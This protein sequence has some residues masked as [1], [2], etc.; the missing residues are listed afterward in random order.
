MIFTCVEQFTSSGGQAV[1]LTRLLLAS[2][3]EGNFTSLDLLKNKTL[4]E[5]AQTEGISLQI[6]TTN[7]H[8]II[9]AYG[10]GCVDITVLFNFFSKH[11]HLKEIS[12]SNYEAVLAKLGDTWVAKTGMSVPLLKE[13]RKA[14]NELISYH[15]AEVSFVIDYSKESLKNPVKDSQIILE[16]NAKNGLPYLL[17][18][19][20]R[21]TFMSSPEDMV[22]LKLPSY[23]RVISD[24]TPLAVNFKEFFNPYKE[25]KYFSYEY[26]EY[27]LPGDNIRDIIGYPENNNL[28]IQDNELDFFNSMKSLIDYATQKYYSGVS[29]A[30]CK[31]YG[32]CDP[33]VTEYLINLAVIVGAWNW[34]HTGKYPI[35]I[36]TDDFNEDGSQV[37]DV[38][39]ESMSSKNYNR[40]FLGEHDHFLDAEVMLT[41][42]IKKA[43]DAGNIYAPAEAVIKLLRWGNR[44]PTMLKL[45]GYDKY[46]DLDSFLITDSSGT[47][48]DKIPIKQD[49][50]TYSPLAFIMA[51][52]KFKDLDFLRST[53]R[54]NAQ[55]D[56]PVG[57]L[58]IRYFEDNAQQY[59][60]MSLPDF[61]EH[62][63]NNP[64]D[65]QGCS[66]NP[67]KEP[68]IQLEPDIFKGTSYSLDDTVSLISKCQ[69]GTKIYYTSEDFENFFLEFNALNSTVSELSILASALTSKELQRNL[70]NRCFTNLEELISNY[71]FESNIEISPKILQGGVK[72]L[73][74][75]TGVKPIL[76]ANVAK[77][78]VPIVLDVAEA[79]LEHRKNKPG[80]EL[81][82][83]DWI[84]MYLYF[85]Q[86][87][88][89]KSLCS[90]LNENTTIAST[91]NAIAKLDA[92]GASV[93][94]GDE[95]DLNF[96]AVTVTG[97]PANAQ[98][99]FPVLDNNRNCIGYM[100]T[101]DTNIRETTHFTFTIKE[102]NL[103][104]PKQTAITMF[105]GLF[106]KLVARCALKKINPDDIN[107][108]FEDEEAYDFF[109]KAI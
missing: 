85:M 14:V 66:Y 40:Q 45:G 34:S 52:G 75:S 69:N 49:G 78:I 43:I 70:D 6:A 80:V 73:K 100:L 30:D 4:F 76:E 83:A 62:L 10:E 106:T 27:L 91:A 20:N 101:S 17:N 23:E 98:F 31:K 53:N 86:K 11:T 71:C 93:N 60:A 79:R 1:K 56:V 99:A 46:L 35:I 109:I 47:F 94:E 108:N 89:I 39:S 65:I 37:D 36:Q 18:P 90:V 16:I 63:K 84:N 21:N 87:A 58:L 59:V 9:L 68:H 25:N 61:I 50:A 104:K 81:L 2:M 29:V 67:N 42:F 24:T 96:K 54:K 44:K 107:I 48:A 88:G 38:S 72:I 7:K 3:E 12:D 95:D 82:P 15:N 33:K 8:P 41:G 105:I 97:I 102:S 55:L 64:G 77:R 28:D 51:N 74:G 26:K 92:F 13:V 22:F 32:H 19:K 5:K 57:A 103:P